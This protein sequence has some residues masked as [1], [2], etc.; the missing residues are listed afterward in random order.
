MSRQIL[1][2]ITTAAV[3][4]FLWALRCVTHL[5]GRSG[6]K[7]KLTKKPITFESSRQ[8]ALKILSDIFDGVANSPTGTLC[9]KGEEFLSIT[10]AWVNGQV[11]I[12]FEKNPHR[13]E[14]EQIY[15]TITTCL[16]RAYDLAE[17]QDITD[18]KLSLL[19]RVQADWAA[20]V[21]EVEKRRCRR[22]HGSYAIS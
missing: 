2:P 14:V 7:E 22:C 9:C 21:R 11:D 18:H 1:T 17:E 20:V 4:L 12:Y 5:W 3:S 19:N 16:R 13:Q 8:A 10:F 6:G 15:P